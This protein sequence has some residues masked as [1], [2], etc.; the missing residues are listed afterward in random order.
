MYYTYILFSPS[1]N[2]YYIGYTS[3]LT[4]RLD[5]HNS[6]WGRF[7]SSGIPWKVVYSEKF[8]L[9]SDAIKREREIKSKKSRKFIEQLIRHAGGR[10]D[11]E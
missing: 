6:A 7:S 3:D 4:K 2:K 9:K 1:I 5:R 8:N 11:S 10:P